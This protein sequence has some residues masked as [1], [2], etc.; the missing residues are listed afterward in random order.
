MYGYGSQ[1]TKKAE[2]W[3]TDAFKLWCCRRL[4]RVPW[5]ARRSKESIDPKGIQPWIFI[6]RTDAEA[7]ILWPLDV[8]TPLIGKEPDAG[9]D[10]RWEEK[11]TTED[12]MVRWH[13]QLNGHESEQAPGDGEGQGLVCFSLWVCKELD[14]TYWLNNWP[15]ERKIP[16]YSAFY[17]NHRNLRM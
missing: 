5:I 7:L 15:K 17:R 12:E 10:W 6:G 13:H 11:G 9:K 3:R 8:K 1:T 14:V 2:C 4:L 16:K